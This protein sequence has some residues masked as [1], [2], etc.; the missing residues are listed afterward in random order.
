M[1]IGD[2]ARVVATDDVGTVYKVESLHG[3]RRYWLSLGV[4][5]DHAMMGRRGQP[6]HPADPYDEDQLEPWE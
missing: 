1:E 5:T 2:A 4:A 3:R 6:V